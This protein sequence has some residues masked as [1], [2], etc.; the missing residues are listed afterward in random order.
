MTDSTIVDV[1]LLWTF[2]SEHPFI[3]NENAGK[4]DLQEVLLPEDMCTSTVY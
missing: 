2:Q 3:S 4:E 1:H